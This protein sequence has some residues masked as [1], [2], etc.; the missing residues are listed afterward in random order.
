M[1]GAHVLQLL[2][3]LGGQLRQIPRPAVGTRTDG[4]L[5]DPPLEALGK[6][7][8][9]RGLLLRRG[10]LPPRRRLGRGGRRCRRLGVVPVRLWRRRLGRRRSLPMLLGQ[11]DAD[12]A[13]QALHQPGLVAQHGLKLCHLFGERFV[14]ALG[15]G[16]GL[17]EGCV[18]GFGVGHHRIRSRDGGRYN[19]G[20]VDDP[21]DWIE[22]SSGHRPAM[23]LAARQTGQVDALQDEGELARVEAD[24]RLALLEGG[25][26]EG[27]P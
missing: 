24:S 1:L 26:L 20:A 6:R 17:D 22:P 25:Q 5:F 8:P 9:L 4:V 14:H 2:G 13:L 7:L 21:G 10:L 11:Q 23:A 12:L 18:G 19:P 15:G 3:D 27:P 16:Q